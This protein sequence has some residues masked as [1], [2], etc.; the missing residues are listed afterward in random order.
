MTALGDYYLNRPGMV[1]MPDEW[2]PAIDTAALGKHIAGL[3]QGGL[4]RVR[5]YRQEW[6]PVAAGL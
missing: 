1:D 5:L 6:R 3:E 4:Y 2:K